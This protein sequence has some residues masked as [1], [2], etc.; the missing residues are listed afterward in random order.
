MTLISQEYLIQNIKLHETTQFGTSGYRY[1]NL[2]DHL[3]RL[4][5]LKTVL[6]YG[7]GKCTLEKE[8]NKLGS[9]AHIVSY[10]PT[11][12]DLAYKLPCDLITCFDV[13]EHIEPTHLENVLLD[14]SSLTKCIGVI[15]IPS[16]PAGATLSDGRN[17]HL[18]QEDLNYW[19]YRISA[20]FQ[21]LHA[22]YLTETILMVVKKRE[23]DDALFHDIECELLKIV[24]KENLKGFYFDGLDLNIMIKKKK[25]FK[26]ISVGI[27]RTLRLGKKTGILKQINTSKKTIRK[28][29]IIEF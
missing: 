25:W 24:K 3:I 7:A 6:D 5:D 27:L 29:N 15:S 10:E 23:N 9:L 26:R 22:N 4:Y 18:I 13:L 19:F 1:A 16:G 14:L 17:A 2:V 21:I 8:L 12:R 28:I 11:N 20:H